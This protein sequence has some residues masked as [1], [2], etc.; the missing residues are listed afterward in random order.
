MQSVALDMGMVSTGKRAN[1]MLIQTVNSLI[2]LPNALKRHFIASNQYFRAR[3]VEC[4][5]CMF[6]REV[7]FVLLSPRHNVTGISDVKFSKGKTFLAKRFI[8]E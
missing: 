7:L 8:F 4:C 6:V 5:E 1:L 3:R 2:S